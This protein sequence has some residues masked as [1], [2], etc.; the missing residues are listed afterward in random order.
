LTEDADLT[1]TVL[2]Y[3]GRIAYAPLARSKTEAPESTSALFRQ[4]FR[5]SYGTFQC[6]WKHRKSFGR[7]SLGWVA[8]PNI[9]VFQLIFPLFA[10]IGDLVLLI[11]FFRRDFTAILVGYLLFL[12]LDLCGSLFAF[13]LD[14][15]KLRHLWVI[16]IQRFYYRQFMY[17]VAWRS[18][19][20]AIKG[21]RQKWHK[22]D[23]QASIDGVRGALP[24]TVGLAEARST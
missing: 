9:L 13:L 8:L 23:R 4:R 18:S 20:A 12:A 1:L 19:F 22:L 17:V 10:P 11:S 3:G 2:E 7:G 5:W 24:A 14:G 21:L 15:K 16:L 6:L